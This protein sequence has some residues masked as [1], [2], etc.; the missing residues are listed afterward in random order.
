M[1][2]ND[3]AKLLQRFEGLVHATEGIEWW[4]ARELQSLLGYSDWRNFL[5]ALDKARESCTQAGQPPDD[6]F[7]VI[8]RR[9][10]IGNG[11]ERSVEDVAMTRY[12]CYLLAQNGDPR[13]EAVAFAQTYFAVQTRRIEL[14]ETRLQIGRAHV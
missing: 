6:H 13:K 12:A 5:Q 9:A 3:I 1:K 2:T 4:C 14:I 11:A 8:E 10:R 7:R